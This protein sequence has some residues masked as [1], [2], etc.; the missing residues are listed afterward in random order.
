MM[1]G[2]AYAQLAEADVDVAVGALQAALAASMRDLPEDL[3]S[4]GAPGLPLPH[5]D[6]G[7][8]PG[9]WREQHM[10][11]GCMNHAA[12]VCDPPESQCAILLQG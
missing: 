5:G 10:A 7:V 4:Q 9:L 2:N 1:A 12:R 6:E 11:V 3:R 8:V